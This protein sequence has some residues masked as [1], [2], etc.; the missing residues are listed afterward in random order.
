MLDDFDCQNDLSPAPQS[1]EEIADPL[2]QTVLLDEKRLS[3]GR[4][5]SGA[6]TGA[7]IDPCASYVT[8][9]V[10]GS[11]TYLGVVADPLDLPGVGQRV[12]VERHDAV[13]RVRIGRK[14]HR[15]AN[16][17]AIVAEGFKAEVLGVGELSDA[18]TSEDCGKIRQNPQPRRNPKKG[19]ARPGVTGREG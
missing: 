1:A 6:K 13:W 3:F 10:A 9:N 18:V 5:V 7:G 4:F 15:C 8:A 16:A 14:P 11:N 17:C 2:D 12:N 19:R